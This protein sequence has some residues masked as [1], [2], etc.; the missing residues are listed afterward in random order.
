MTNENRKRVAKI[1]AIAILAGGITYET[2]TFKKNLRINDT[3]QNVVEVFNDDTKLDEAVTENLAT[4]DDI[5]ILKAADKL[6]SYIDIVEQLEN[7][8]FQEVKDLD[9]LS[10]EDYQLANKLTKEDIELLM[11]VVETDNDSLK[12]QEVRIKAAKI[13]S[14]INQQEKD[15]IK[16]NGK[17]V[18][19]N[20]LKWVTKSSIAEEFDLDASE[21]DNVEI[22]PAKKISDMRFFITYNGEK[23]SISSRKSSIYD[24]LYCY[25]QINSVEDLGEN[26]NELYKEAISYAKIATMTGVKEQNNTIE[27]IRSL[28][29]AKKVLKK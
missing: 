5:S 19:S 22:P 7:Y 20:L 27:N 29:E 15:W 9:E 8:N 4:Y 18:T 1:T 26:E 23:Y 3:L 21:I 12:S 11:Q 14:Y 24:T 2:A 16:N 25:Y 6:E 17:E 13:L 28:K 10:Q